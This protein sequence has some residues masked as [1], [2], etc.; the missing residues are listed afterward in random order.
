MGPVLPDYA[1]FGDAV[2]LDWYAVDLNL[3]QLLDR[4]L[5]DPD[6]RTFAE[7]HVGRY[8]VL[9]GG[10]L[11]RRADVTDQHPPVLVSRDRWGVEVDRA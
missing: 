9:C 11:A 3:R 6:D 8:G 2:G 10:D 1:E 7:E 4:L 5:P